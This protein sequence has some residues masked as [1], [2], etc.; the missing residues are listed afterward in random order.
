MVDA[1]PPVTTQL[2]HEIGT[3]FVGYR[4]EA[5]IGRGAMGVVYRAYDLRL[6]RTVALKLV[7][8]ELALDAHFRTRFVRETELAMSLEHPNVVPIYD[9]GDVDSRLYLAM[10]LVDGSDLRALLRSDG[11]L[12]PARAFAIC[13]QVGAAL[14]AAHARG[15]VHCDV[16][17]S[18][19]LLDQDE[20]VYVA[21]LGLSRRLED[22][23]P[24]DESSMG[25]PAYLAPEH[26]EGLPID[27]RA[28]VYSLGC[29]LYECMTGELPFTRDSRLALAWAHLEEDPPRA[30]ERNPKL[31]GGI[32]AVLA[33]ALAKEPAQR[34]SSC[35]AL[36]DDAQRALGLGRPAGVRRRRLMLLAAALVALAAAAVAV[37]ALQDGGTAQPTPRLNTLVRIDPRTNEVTDV[38]PV[39]KLP[40]AS[41]FGGGV[42]WVYNH[43]SGTLSEVDAAAAVVR[44]T[45]PVGTT[46]QMTLPY[47]PALVADD[48]GAWIIGSDFESG[49]SFVTNVRRD[50]GK[51]VYSLDVDPVAVSLG[52][53]AV[54]VL[55]SRK[56]RYDL[57]RID[58]TTGRITGR[59]TFRRKVESLTAGLDAVWVLASLPG[60]L[61]QVDPRN[62][63]TI[64]V[65]AVGDRAVRPAVRD[66]QIWV[67]IQGGGGN[68]VVVDGETLGIVGNLGCCLPSEGSDAE[69]FGSDWM[70][71]WPTGDVVRW[72]LATR[73]LTRSISLV[74]SPRWGG[75][76]LA[77]IAIGAGA[78]WVTV[79]PSGGETCPSLG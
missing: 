23:R 27:G 30:S 8:P 77:S 68:T 75:P 78:V 14:D 3:D 26:I 61:Y 62:L 22:Q 32:D 55:G 48:D 63:R 17:P 49:R 33:K 2:Q 21:D 54:W 73:Q 5:L 57:L 16:K 15:L 60:V 69:G 12:E 35:A 70:I 72:N 10:R 39:Q 50:G 41:A 65:V 45:V 56:S 11:P 31:P 7:A 29:L 64:G 58:Q 20:H 76:C 9:A 13:S 6:K 51:Y 71:S 74:R 19:V 47:G 25:T 1:S 37:V 43:A 44:R 34:Y 28:D 59:T 67:G 42:V 18:N 52:E 24:G 40:Y 53:G 36:L 38:I 79:A 66:G 4:I 46:S